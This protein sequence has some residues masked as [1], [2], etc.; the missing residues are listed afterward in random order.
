MTLNSYKQQINIDYFIKTINISL[1]KK[2][3]FSV[4]TWV[5][6]MNSIQYSNSWFEDLTGIF[7][8]P[9]YNEV[10]Y[11]D[12]QIQCNIDIKFTISREL[13]RFLYFPIGKIAYNIDVKFQTSMKALEILKKI[14]KQLE[15]QL[16]PN[17]EWF[18]SRF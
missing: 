8:K 12:K 3:W 13:L 11:S 9:L 18:K 16:S 17:D 15:Q 2:E 1:T 6:N 5:N 14:D 7:L 10:T 4:I